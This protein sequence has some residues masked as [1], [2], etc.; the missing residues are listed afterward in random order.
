MR[1]TSDP[2]RIWRLPRKE[3]KGFGVMLIPNPPLTAIA[4]EIKYA[5]FLGLNISMDYWVSGSAIAL[6]LCKDAN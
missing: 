1:V 5:R 3:G 6:V 2:V 4:F